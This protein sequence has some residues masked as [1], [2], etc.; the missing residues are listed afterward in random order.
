MLASITPLELKARIEKSDIVY[1]VDVRESWEYDEVNI[2]ANNIPLGSL[3]EYLEQLSPLRNQEI[4]VHC[5]T[6]GRSTQAQKYLQKQGFTQVR[7]LLG[8][9]EGYLKLTH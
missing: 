7:N 6:G 9:I 4:I 5:K 2:G 3:P 8:G 1:I